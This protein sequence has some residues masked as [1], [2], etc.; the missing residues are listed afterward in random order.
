MRERQGSPAVHR[1][2]RGVAALAGGAAEAV[3]DA[4]ARAVTDRA[5]VAG[6]A[7]GVG[8][9]VRLEAVRLAAAAA[10]RGTVD[11]VE[12]GRAVELDRGAADAVTAGRLATVAA[13]IPGVAHQRPAVGAVG[14]LRLSAG[15]EDQAA[16]VDR[17]AG[18]AALAVEAARF[19]AG[20]TGDHRADDVAAGSIK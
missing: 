20:G 17:H 14:E 3:A 13:A 16:V 10:V 7:V 1:Q 19:V 12:A 5:D 6:G 11:S 4:Q 8:D 2:R 18:V 9:A 15:A